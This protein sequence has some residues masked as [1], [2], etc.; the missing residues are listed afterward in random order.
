MNNK[1]TLLRYLMTL[2]LGMFLWAGN[3]QVNAQC[4]N[5]NQS[6]GTVFEP[7]QC[8]GMPQF[9]VN[10]QAATYS[11]IK[12]TVGN[13]YLFS[14][15]IN[16]DY[17]T[18][19]NSEGNT[20]HIHGITPITYIPTADGE[21]RFYI[22]KN[23]LC[24]GDG[25][26]YRR[27]EISCL[28]TSEI[29]STFPYFEGFET[30]NIHDTPVANWI[31][32]VAGTTYLWRAKNNYSTISYPPGFPR[33]GEWNG[34][35]INERYR[36]MFQKFNLVAGTHYTFKMYARRSSDEYN[37]NLA[38]ITVKIGNSPDAYGM[39][40]G[41]TIVETTELIGPDYQMLIGTFIPT[42]DGL[43]YLGI[44]GDTRYKFAH[45]SIDDIS[46]IETP[47][48]PIF[49]ILPELASADFGT[50]S[51]GAPPPPVQTFFI[52]NKGLGTVKI[53]AIEI[54]GT[55]A[56]Q[57][58]L[59]YLNGDPIELNYQDS[60]SIDVIFKPTN[61][62]SKTA[63]LDISYTLL[64]KTGNLMDTY[65]HIV[66]L[67]G[68]GNIPPQGALCSNPLLLQFP[69]I[70][71]SGNTGDYGNDYSP[72]H[73]EKY[74]G[75]GGDDF[76]DPEYLNGD[77][78]VYQFILDAAYALE[79]TITTS[80]S[81]I[82]A[83]IFE[84]CPNSNEPPTPLIFRGTS[85]S[86]LNFPK[87]E[88]PMSV[89]VPR[90]ELDEY[91]ILP[92]GTY[93]LIISSDPD[94]D[95][96][97]QSIDYTIDLILKYVGPEESTFNGK[98]NWS[99]SERWTNGLPGFATNVS[100]EG[101]VNV[102][103]NY[104]CKG[105]T[106]SSSLTFAGLGNELS[107]EYLYIGPLGAVTVI[108]EG[109]KINSMGLYIGSD[110]TGTGSFIGNEENYYF[111]DNWGYSDITIERY[112]TGGWVTENSGWHQISSPVEEQSI[113]SFKV[114]Q[115]KYDFYAWDESENIW[116]NY[117]DAGWTGGENFNVGQGYF[118]SY[119][120]DATTKMF[121]G[122]L[123]N[124]NV[125]KVNLSKINAGWHL[126]GNPF[127]SAVKWN[128]GTNWS[129][130]NVAG[131]A[132]IWHE[133]NKSY[134]DIAPNGIIP[135]AQGFMVQVESALN[136]ITIPA[137]SRVHN[138]QP[139]YKSGNEQLL[140]VA[141][142]TEGGST[143]ESKIIVNSMSTVGFDFSY[144]SR[145]LAGYAPAFYSVVGDEM[146]STN[147]LPELNSGKAIPFGFVKNAASDFTIEL[148]ESI[149]GRVIYLTDNKTNKVTNLSETPV[150]SFTSNEGDDATRFLITFGTLG[151]NSP[152]S[153]DVAQV[154]AYGDVLYV[155]TSG[156]EAALV[157]VYNLTGQ[158]VM[159]G[160]TGG[161]A[162]STFNASAL[163]NG[164]Y[165]VTVIS[166]Q[167]VVSQKVVI[168]K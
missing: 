25:D 135:S 42:R 59:T 78:V 106:V 155:S 83:F 31:H 149:P 12:L 109:N 120:A 138:S 33:T 68:N 167:G 63:S 58:G 11:K 126:L 37:N 54:S 166:K 45:I 13:T 92:A 164:V 79:G 14:S 158:L 36:W 64:D 43:H 15:F 160:K 32:E 122:D 56:N 107:C 21:F 9:I 133:T 22:H 163:I 108:G 168:R 102:N 55:D 61:E 53:T 20:V 50:V 2:T 101:E 140:L 10:A 89:G 131:N 110:A 77:E 103:G 139:F 5:G 49:K 60:I 113:S 73:I 127:V 81:S 115:D 112:F 104:E 17:I 71:I 75:W 124:T 97:N 3:Y 41:N 152:A 93:F 76:Y 153:T 30:G 82:G 47:I 57:F 159:Q 23:S 100:I 130:D 44:V 85:G 143:Q 117:K 69:A 4:T 62:G 94:S 6:S 156:K 38:E 118:V 72:W 145:F 1:T 88:G 116:M 19:S 121:D 141:A 128:D 91:D 148:K 125:T 111:V 142:E 119:E 66:T 8:N 151:I 51:I 18:V 87:S 165:V 99:D 28:P 39:E 144:D 35:L 84:D 161:N 134:S 150:Y 27:L 46:I 24:E 7:T 74:E 146:L 40:H 48:A 105:L 136:S 26:T 96:E 162:L 65:I 95:G 86:T 98:G 132:K 34:Y 80:E 154:Y 123:N 90:G 16:T 70:N 52:S 67:T 129:L 114:Y 29:I 137:A 157:N 147:S